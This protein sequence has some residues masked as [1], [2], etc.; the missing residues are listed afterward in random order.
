MKPFIFKLQVALNL[1]LKEEDAKKEEL[2]KAQKIYNE[3]LKKITLLRNRLNQIQE[4]V[5]KKQNAIIDVFEIRGLQDYIPVLMDTIRQQETTL[6]KS[7]QE[8]ELVRSK[9]LEIMKDRKVLEKLKA[10]H[11]QDYMMECLREEQKE[12]DEMATIG[13]IHKDSAV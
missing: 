7:R 12:I 1:K 6:E 8:M 4:M 2:G 11:Y 10:R 5:R 13:Y 9:L 3:N